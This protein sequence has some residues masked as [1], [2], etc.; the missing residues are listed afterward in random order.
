MP[1]SATKAE[2]YLNPVRAGV[3][4]APREETAVMLPQA[5]VQIAAYGDLSFNSADQWRE[6]ADLFVESRTIIESIV[7]N[8]ADS[9]LK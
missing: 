8:S 7:A 6:Q 1:A 9:L 4:Q 3:W 2:W 5:F